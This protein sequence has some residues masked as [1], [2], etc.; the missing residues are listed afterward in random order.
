MDDLELLEC[1]IY[2]KI[3]D[4][5]YR[6]GIAIRAGNKKLELALI[7]KLTGLQDSLDLLHQVQEEE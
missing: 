6:K 2:T 4:T 1:L 5:K 7:N 3:Y